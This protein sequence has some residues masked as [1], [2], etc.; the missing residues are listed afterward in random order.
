VVV[1]HLYRGAHQQL[2]CRQHALA[3]RREQLLFPNGTQSRSLT[4]VPQRKRNAL[5]QS[6]ASYLQLV[7]QLA[8]ERLRQPGKRLDRTIALGL[9]T[10]VD[11]NTDGPELLD[12]VGSLPQMCITSPW[13]APSAKQGRIAP[14]F[15]QT[16]HSTPRKP[17]GIN[18]ALHP[19]PA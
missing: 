18:R 7:T 1:L 9:A 6:A 17:F 3:Y 4:A 14:R 10:I 16:R 19:I 2:Y 5:P 15:I 12:P 8:E 13:I 11:K